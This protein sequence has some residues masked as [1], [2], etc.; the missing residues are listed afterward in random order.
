MYIHAETLFSVGLV[1]TSSAT[2]ILVVRSDGGSQTGDLS[3]PVAV[4]G[5]GTIYYRGARVIR[6]LISNFL[7]NSTVGVSK[8]TDVVISGCSAGGLSTFF[9]GMCVLILL[10]EISGWRVDVLPRNMI[11]YY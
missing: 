9:H 10:S 3:A 1:H 4:P 7:A 5:K 6:S 2:C 8:A 11:Y